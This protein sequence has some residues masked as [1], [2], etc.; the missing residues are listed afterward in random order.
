MDDALYDEFAG[1]EQDHWWFQ[2][3]RRVVTAVL[4]RRLGRE[5]RRDILDIGCGTGE[6]VDMLLEFGPVTAM[7]ASPRA[8]AACQERLGST[9]AL[10]VGTLPDDLSGNPDLVTAFDVIEH[11]DD[12]VKTLTRVHEM[13]PPGGFFVCTVPAFMFLWSEHDDVNHHRRRYTKA[14]LHRSLRTAGFQV[15]W[16]SYFNSLLFPAVAAVRLLH[17]LGKDRPARSDLATPPPWANRLLTFLFGAE[18]WAL[19]YASLPVGVSLVAVAR[20]AESDRIA[21]A[22]PRS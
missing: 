21:P 11:L 16:I 7:D 1:M 6:M 22:E 9:V 2:G 8:V 15:E 19:R 13:L 5:P 20:K 17:R 12:D 18:R 10:R 4:R 14:T 3:R